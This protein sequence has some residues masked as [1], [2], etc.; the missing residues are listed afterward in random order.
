MDSFF[1][2]GPL[3]LVFI[4][5]FALIFLGPQ[6]LPGVLREGIKLLRKARELT[7]EVTSMVN[8]ELGDLTKDIQELNPRHQLDKALNPPP[9]PKKP[10]KAAENPSSTT[11]G[12]PSPDPIS[13]A[14]AAAVAA[15]ATSASSPTPDAPQ[16]DDAPEQTTEDPPPPKPAAKDREAMSAAWT[17]KPA[18]TR[19]PNPNAVARDSDG[20][21]ASPQDERPLAALEQDRP[22][23][24]KRAAPGPVNGSQQKNGADHADTPQPETSQAETQSD[25]QGKGS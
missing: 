22:D 10:P 2:I 25:E 21:T 18:I 20:H 8:N 9:K 12:D 5:I 1:G 13:P 6:R 4:I 24:E 14:S 11:E 19:Q 3:E 16:A 17:G 7:D 23:R 15:N